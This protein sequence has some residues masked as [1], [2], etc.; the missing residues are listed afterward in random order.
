MFNGEKNSA[1]QDN[2]PSYTYDRTHDLI[3]LYTYNKEEVFTCY[4][5]D[6]Y[7]FH[8]TFL[9]SNYSTTLL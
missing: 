3:M 2:I 8:Y 4:S 5:M 1:N 9:S 7:K 6:N